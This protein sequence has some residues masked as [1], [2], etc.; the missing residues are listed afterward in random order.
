MLINK[1]LIS[2]IFICFLCFVPRMNHGA[3]EDRAA[4][5]GSVPFL[6]QV[7]S[8]GDGLSGGV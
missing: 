8:S 2:K 4:V 6:L 1:Y 3:W 7:L 5:S